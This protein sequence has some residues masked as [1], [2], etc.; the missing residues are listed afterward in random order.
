MISI[1]DV[2]ALGIPTIL[3]PPEDNGPAASSCHR[4]EAFRPDPQRSCNLQVDPEIHLPSPGFDVNIAYYYN[5]SADNNGPFG[6]GRT[7]S[8]NLTAQASGSPA[9]VTLTRANGAIVSFQ[10]NGSGTFLPQTPGVLN[11]LVKDTVDSLWKETTPDGMTTAYPLDTTGQITSVVYQQDAAGNTHSFSYSGGLLQTLQD[12]VGR[13]V[14]FSYSGGLLQD[15]EDWAGRRTTFQYNTLIASPANLLTT[16]IG[17]TGCQTGYQ[18]A[19]FTL[20]SN[21]LLH[22]PAVIWR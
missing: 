9:I 18:Y 11:T 7:I 14:S 1:I 10:D 2:E 12:A 22:V 5:A 17:P 16:V 20:F 4:C 6:Y 3:L 8:P 21:G 19:T 15:I 13:F